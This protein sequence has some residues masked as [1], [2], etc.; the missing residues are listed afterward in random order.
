M[1][2]NSFIMRS[3]VVWSKLAEWLTSCWT[4]F[5]CYSTWWLRYR[6]GV[7]CGVKWRRGWWGAGGARKIRMENPRL[8]STS[9]QRCFLCL[10][11][12][13]SRCYITYCYV[14]MIKLILSLKCTQP[15]T[16]IQVV[17]TIRCFPTL[18]K[19]GK[20]CIL[21]A[22]AA[23]TATTYSFACGVLGG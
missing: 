11:K 16:F 19:V 23:L 14:K 12:K 22:E 2:E 9:Y 15:C 4:W 21:V 13:M 3:R 17:N 5:E 20:I 7:T 1:E 8:K 6:T 10:V 18:K